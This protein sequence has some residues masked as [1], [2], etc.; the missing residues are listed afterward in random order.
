MYGLM[1]A[2]ASAPVALGAT[3]LNRLAITL[4]EAVLLGVGVLVW[5]SGR[6]R[7]VEDAVRNA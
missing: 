4:V 5:R 7:A 6:D 1:L 2:V 3:V